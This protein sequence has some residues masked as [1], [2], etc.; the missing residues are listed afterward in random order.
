MKTTNKPM[1]PPRFKND[2]PVRL[3]AIQAIAIKRMRV[4]LT[5][6]EMTLLSG[7]YLIEHTTKT[8]L[9]SISEIKHL[10]SPWDPSY[11][12]RKLKVLMRKGYLKRALPGFRARY[13]LLTSEGLQLCKEWNQLLL[14]TYWNFMDQKPKKKYNFLYGKHL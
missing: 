14:N 7:L 6:N 12:H 10:L 8:P 5:K 1:I 4:R 2:F 3:L 9:L 11:L 13:Y